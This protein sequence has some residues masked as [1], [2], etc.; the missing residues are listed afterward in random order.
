[1]TMRAGKDAHRDDVDILLERCFSN[2]LRCLTKARVN[3][4]EARV[5]QCARDDLRAAVMPVKARFRH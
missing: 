1:M 4:L 2:L 5:A 3:D